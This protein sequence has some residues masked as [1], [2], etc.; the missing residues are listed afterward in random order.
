VPGQRN[1]L[2][3]AHGF[4]RVGGTCKETEAVCNPSG[5]G[6]LGWTR[7]GEAKDMKTLYRPSLPEATDGNYSIIPNIYFDEILPRLTATQ[8]KVFLVFLRECYGW[9]NEYFTI[10][11]RQIAEQANVSRPTAG[12]A[13]E[14]LIS[15]GLVVRW[16]KGSFLS[17]NAKI[18]SRY[19]VTT[20][21][22]E[23]L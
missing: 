16:R 2:Q 6:C 7:I 11:I 18:A 4:R 17:R 22:I 5:S 9:H 20:G 13:V 21:P 14:E 10:S 15:L 3:A 23:L 1:A 12:R 8:G 19:S